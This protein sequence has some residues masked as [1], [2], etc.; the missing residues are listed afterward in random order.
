MNKN[1]CIRCKHLYQSVAWCS[2]FGPKKIL[3]NGMYC[4]IECSGFLPNDGRRFSFV[5]EKLDA[6]RG[7][8][9]SC[10]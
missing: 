7:L 9:G 5:E 4:T 3:R 6:G 1:L 10:L 8:S 2:K